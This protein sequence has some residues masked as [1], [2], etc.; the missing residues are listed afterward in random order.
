MWLLGHPWSCC[1]EREQMVGG[2]ADGMAVS[3]S[4]RG[5]SQLLASICLSRA[6]VGFFLRALKRKWRAWRR[7]YL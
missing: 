4:G 3:I 1:G 6:A 7:R 5:R 2:L